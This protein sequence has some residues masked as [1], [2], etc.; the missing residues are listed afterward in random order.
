M[1]SLPGSDVWSDSVFHLRFI[2]EVAMKAGEWDLA[3][4]VAHQLETHAPYYAGDHSILSLVAQHDGDKAEASR[5]S[6]L[7]RKLLQP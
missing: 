1:R 2:A 5:E 6:D 3:R 7:A 4:F